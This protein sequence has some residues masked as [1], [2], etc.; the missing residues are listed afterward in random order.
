MTDSIHEGFCAQIEDYLASVR[1]D[2]T[3]FGRK[4]MNDPNFV[5]TLRKGRSP[6]ARTM[7]RV[8]GF[9]DANPPPAGDQP[10]A[11]DQEVA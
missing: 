2:P 6:S 11:Q 9:I 10:P 4:A 8:R 1:M 3:T 5:F 7:D